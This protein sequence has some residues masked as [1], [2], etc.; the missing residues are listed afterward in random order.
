MLDGSLALA[1]PTKF[2]QSLTVKDLA[3]PKII[4]RSLDEKGIIWFEGEFSI[5]QNNI[6]LL[7]S[8]DI[9]V[10]N[11]LLQILNAANKLNISFLNTGFEITTTLNFQKNWGLGTSSTLINNVAQWAHIDPYKLLDLTFGGSGFDI[12]CAQNNTPITYQL[13][14]NS[15]LVNP[16]DFNPTFKSHL[17]FVYLN[18]KQNSR[19]SIA[20]YKEKMTSLDTIEKA[21]HLTQKIIQAKDLKTFCDL[22]EA[23]ENLI[24]NLLN[25][26]PIKQVLFPDF[27][28]SIKS[29]GGWG[30]DF[31]LAASEKNPESYFKNKGFKTIIPYSEMVLN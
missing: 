4:W 28:G 27:N 24:S 9:E 19:E 18:K 21:S 15:R 5:S 8:S 29:L 11:R 12:A 2:G 17:Y 30:G 7:T 3:Y 20:T 13:K 23:H 10:S 16:I 22:I 31:I 1:I 6:K 14:N 25:I 26:K